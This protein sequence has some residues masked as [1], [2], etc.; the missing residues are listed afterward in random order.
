MLL[1]GLLVLSAVS[2]FAYNSMED[3]RAADAS[4]RIAG[5]LAAQIAARTEGGTDGAGADGTDAGLSVDGEA[6]MGILDIPA[7]GLSLPVMNDW[8]YARLRISPCRYSGSLEDGI[9][10]AA[11]N[12]RRHFGRIHLL[13]YGDALSFTGARG[14]TVGY[15]V[16]DIETL[17][18]TAVEDMSESGYAL[19]LFTCT[20]GGS[21]RVAV[22]CDRLSPAPAAP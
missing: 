19:T 4:G 1:G 5:A 11:H 21:A 15:A 13:S 3:R 8:S 20:Y 14:N 7:L 18:A 6:Y 2:L 16:A 17:E 22:R 10:I 9:V 12:Y